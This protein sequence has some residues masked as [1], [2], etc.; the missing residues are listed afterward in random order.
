M[1]HQ[2]IVTYDISDA[3]RLRGVHKLMLGFGDH[4]QLSV[5]LCELSDRERAV[6]EGRLLELIHHRE[7]QVILVRL[8]PASPETDAR[9]HALGRPCA[10][11]ERRAVVV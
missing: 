1:R 11:R 3:K 7:D 5:F 8:G 9:V 4:L 10:A 6:L 2:F